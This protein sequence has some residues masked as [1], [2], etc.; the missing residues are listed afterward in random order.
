M[1]ATFTAADFRDAIR[2]ARPR[3]IVTVHQ[4]GGGTATLYVGAPDA[5]SRFALAIGPG[6]YDWRHPWESWFE[7]S[8]TAVGPDDDGATVPVYPVTFAGIVHTATIMLGGPTR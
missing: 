4:T 3:E 7:L 1:H 6:S 8:E 5:R 2:E